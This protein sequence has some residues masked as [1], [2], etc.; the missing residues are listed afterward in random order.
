MAEYRL[1]G[2]DALHRTLADVVAEARQWWADHYGTAPMDIQVRAGSGIP[3]T[4]EVRN[5]SPGVVR[6]VP[7]APTQ[8][9]MAL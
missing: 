2:P 4:V 8:E 3:G 1:F 5:C 7:L 9:T 6:L